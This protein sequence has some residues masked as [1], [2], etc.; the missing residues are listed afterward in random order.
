[1]Q[2]KF[3][4]DILMKEYL[5][6]EISSYRFDIFKGLKKEFLESDYLFANLETPL[7]NK[8]I[9]PADKKSGYIVGVKD[10]IA[11]YFANAG[12]SVFCL[13]N[14]HIM[15]YG[16]EGLINTV[17]VLNKNGIKTV[18]AGTDLEN[19]C[20]PIILTQEGVKVGILAYSNAYNATLTS[21]GCA[22]FNMEIIKKNVEELNSRVDYIV[23]SVHQG[24]ELSDY[25]IPEHIKQCRKIIKYGADIVIGHH[26]HVLQGYEQINNKWIFYSINSLVFDQ[27]DFDR[28][29]ARENSFLKKAGILFPGDDL[30][31]RE[32]VIVDVEFLKNKFNV[33]LIPLYLDSNSQ[34]PFIPKE[35]DGDR[36]IKRLNKISEAFSDPSMPVLSKLHKIYVLENIKDTIRKGP[37]EIL[38]KVTVNNLKKILSSFRILDNTN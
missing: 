20:S 2:I 32:S 17:D 37:Q 12:F 10:K 18:G 34:A 26:P 38:K 27:D 21:P 11:P 15:D 36:I 8:T 6:N 25:P 22:P 1:M 19:A 16:R 24:F 4:G 14:N 30:R 33:C 13:A 31:T 23:V 35:Q 9:I 3:F 5:A 7:I 28:K 29:H